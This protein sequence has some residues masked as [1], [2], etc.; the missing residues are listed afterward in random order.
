M[1]AGYPGK[2]F[3]CYHFNTVLGF[4]RS[5]FV[6]YFIVLFPDEFTCHMFIR[7]ASGLSHVWT[8]K[9]YRPE[10]REVIQ[11]LRANITLAEDLSLV[12]G[13][14]ISTCNSRSRGAGAIFRPP[15]VPALRCT[16]PQTD[17]QTHTHIHSDTHTHNKTIY[18]TMLI[19]LYI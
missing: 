19:S 16:Y 8:L 9:F 17:I 18:T 7:N 12:P 15:R 10:V 4:L 3:Y 1:L 14:Q 5:I 13:I 2:P 6:K 11:W